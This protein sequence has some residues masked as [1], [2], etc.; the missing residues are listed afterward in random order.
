VRTCRFQICEKIYALLLVDT[1]QT[2]EEASLQAKSKWSYR[3]DYC[4]AGFDDI[5]IQYLFFPHL[6][7]VGSIAECRDE[8]RQM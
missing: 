8:P 2:E 3:I 6:L 5:D 7:E 1:S 4:L